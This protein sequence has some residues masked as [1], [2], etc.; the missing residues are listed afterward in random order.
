MYCDN[1]IIFLC[2]VQLQKHAAKHAKIQA[3]FRQ[4]PLEFR[5]SPLF[6]QSRGQPTFGEFGGK[7]Q[8]WRAAATQAPV[9]MRLLLGLYLCLCD[10]VKITGVWSVITV[11][12]RCHQAGRST[13]PVRAVC[14]RLSLTSGEWSG[15]NDQWSLWWLLTSLR[16]ERYVTSL[17]YVVTSS[18]AV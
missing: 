7:G 10:N 14:R 16:W 13:S 17:G 9:A 2:S 1:F 8:I 6:R 4:T 18:G 11:H 3:R 15:R 12:C 5:A